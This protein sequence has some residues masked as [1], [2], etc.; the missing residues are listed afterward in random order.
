MPVLPLVGSRSFRPGWS[1]P[2]ASA[3]SII[4]FATRSLIE[5]V[6]EEKPPGERVSAPE[7]QLQR[8]VR[9]DRS[10][11]PR[12]HTEHAAFSAA[13]RELRRRW[14]RE[15]APVAGADA[16]REDG[17]LA[18]EPEDRAVDDGNL[19]PDRRVVHQVSRRE[20][21]GAV[22]DDVPAV[23]ENALD[24]LRRQALL[25]GNDADV[26]VERLEGALRREDL[27]VAQAVGR[28]DDL[29]L[30]VR[31][32]D[33]VRVDDAERADAGCGEIERG[34]GAETA[35]ADEEHPCVEETLL[36]LF[37]DLGNQQVPAVARSLLRR[38]RTRDRDLEPVAL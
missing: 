21:V 33:H 26:R 2:A 38:E 22:D 24:V 35:G 23:L 17:D 20:V 11:D 4:A 3:R 27:R 32:V 13:R 29:A 6:E 36:T 10:D 12:Q 1:S 19:V 16:R 8:L 18:F 30:Q 25:E 28:V 37:A 5:R 31:L 34:G 9:L 14:V 7:D 15:E